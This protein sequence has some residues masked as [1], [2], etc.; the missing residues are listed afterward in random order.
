MFTVE[1]LRPTNW[2]RLQSLRIAALSESDAI[3]G[4]LAMEIAA[5]AEYWQ[6]LLT[7]GT[8]ISLKWEGEDVGMLVVTPPPLDRYGDCWIKSWWIA[9]KFRNQGGAKIMLDWLTEFSHQQNWRIQALGVFES[10]VAA[11]STYQRLGFSPVGDRKPSSREGEFFILM[12]R[13]LSGD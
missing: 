5:P 6:E 8:W 1:V 9:P 12:A 7:N 11:I 3:H 10:N 2:R 13:E 4:D